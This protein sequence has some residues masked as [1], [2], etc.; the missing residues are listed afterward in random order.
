MKPID[1]LKHEYKLG[2]YYFSGNF[3]SRGS[4]VFPGLFV[5]VE[6]FP[7]LINPIRKMSNEVA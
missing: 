7:N 6:S 4:Y 3:L 2:S 1:F 5:K